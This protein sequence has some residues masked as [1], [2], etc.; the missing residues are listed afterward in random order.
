MIKMTLRK[1]IAETEYVGHLMIPSLIKSV[2]A[3]ARGL[4][5]KCIRAATHE[6]EVTYTDSKNREWRYLGN[7]AARECS[8]RKW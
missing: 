8:C 5:M 2:H 7:L 3:K 6:S 4:N 1:R